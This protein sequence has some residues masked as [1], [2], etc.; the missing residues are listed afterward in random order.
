MALGDELWLHCA[1]VA[2]V[3]RRYR[4]YNNN[5]DTNAAASLSSLSS[6]Q[7]AVVERDAIAKVFSLSLFVFVFSMRKI[8]CFFIEK[9]HKGINTSTFDSHY[10][11][12]HYETNAPIGNFDIM[13]RFVFVVHFSIIRFMRC[14]CFDGSIV[15]L[16]FLKQLL[17]TTMIGVKQQLEFSTMFV[18]VRHH[19][20][21]RQPSAI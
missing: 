3:I 19:Q 8:Q 12:C 17:T 15:F 11:T 13:C 18:V 5:G 20:R 10:V 21:R 4:N 2:S 6:I 16:N 14:V 7:F 1:A 9:K